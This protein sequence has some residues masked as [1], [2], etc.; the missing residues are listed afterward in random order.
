MAVPGN[1]SRMARAASSP[2]V[3]CV[4]GMRMST[5]TRS[6]SW[7][8]TSSSRA[9]ASPA[10]ATTSNEVLCSRLTSPSRRRTSSSATITRG[11]RA[12]IWLQVSQPP[13]YGRH[14]AMRADPAHTMQEQAALRRVATLVAHGVPAAELFGGVAEEVGRLLDADLAGMIRFEED[15]SVVPVAT[16]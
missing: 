12:V 14:L 7:R 10:W 16:W 2:S 9:E 4:G 3:V 15:G 1:A 5:S 8:L 13:G 11:L 6:G